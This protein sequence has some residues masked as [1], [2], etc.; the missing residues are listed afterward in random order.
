MT[1]SGRPAFRLVDEYSVR[2][3]VDGVRDGRGLSAIEFP[4]ELDSEVGWL[5]RHDSNPTL[6]AERFDTVT[7]VKAGCELVSDRRRNDHLTELGVDQV[8]PLDE[9]QIQQ[10]RRVRDDRHSRAYSTSS[11]R[12]SSV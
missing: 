2:V 4:L 11:A 8:K 5:R 1:R 7:A 10:W 6:I 3:D 9:C 12:S